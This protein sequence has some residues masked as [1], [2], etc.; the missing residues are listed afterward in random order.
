MG[1]KMN[2]YSSLAKQGVQFLQL[3]KENSLYSSL[4]IIATFIITNKIL[5]PLFSS[6]KSIKNNKFYAMRIERLIEFFAEK[7][8][9]NFIFSYLNFALEKPKEIDEDDFNG[10]P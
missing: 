7:K 2:N 8:S 5:I 6:R 4:T 10:N 9:K 3:I 1:D